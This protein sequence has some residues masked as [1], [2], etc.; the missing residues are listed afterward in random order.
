[1]MT[2]KADLSHLTIHDP[3]DAPAAI[4]SITLRTAANDTRRPPV[5]DPVDS[6]MG[7]DHLSSPNPYATVYAPATRLPAPETLPPTAPNGYVGLGCVASLED[8]DEQL[9]AGTI[10][11]QSTTN[12]RG[13][14]C[15]KFRVEP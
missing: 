6:L 15:L 13:T 4:D 11:K 7:Y 14:D 10:A 3:E 12:W 8:G 5:A 9:V 2:S 1:M